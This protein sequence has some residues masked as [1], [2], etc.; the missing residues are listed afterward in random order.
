[1]IKFQTVYNF[2]LD[3]VMV[4]YYNNILEPL[5][6]GQDEDL[7]ECLRQKRMLKTVVKCLVSPEYMQ[8]KSYTRNK[9]IPA[10]RCY[11]KVCK[12]YLKYHSVRTKSVLG[13]YFASFG[14]ILKIY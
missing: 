13:G 9:E 1:M 8:T 4:H 2:V 7:I 6:N 10:F 14:S 11:T 12:D 3:T 5:L